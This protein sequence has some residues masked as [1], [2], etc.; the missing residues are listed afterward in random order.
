MS[1]STAIPEPPACHALAASS[2]LR[3][4]GVGSAPALVLGGAILLWG[5]NW[6]VMKLGLGHVSPLWF[7]ALRFATGAACLF[8]WQ[9]ARGAVW[10]PRG[11]DLP[12]IASIGL[13]Q[14]MLF[15]ALGAVAMTHLPAGRS[16]ILSY[17]TPIWVVPMAVLVFGER[18][19]RLQWAGIG[20]AALG[21]A[22]LFNPHAIDW[23]DGTVLGAHGMLLAASAAWA[24]CILHLRHGRSAASAA[25]LAPWQM[26]LAAAVLLPLAR[27]T[28]GPFTGDGTVTFWACLIFVGPLAT[29]FGFCAVNAA[30]RQ[31]PASRMSTLMLAVPVTGLAIATVT[32]HEMPEPDLVLGALAIILGIAAS[33]VPARLTHPHRRKARN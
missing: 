5:A 4:A 29:A 14:M 27:A 12:F 19:G 11:A 17:T 21:V 15:T 28:E 7:S 25:Q 9:A 18:L 33:A 1:A 31:V 22:I 3:R 20:L 26:L 2:A 24:V 8:A 30:S 23:R 6:P 13:L 10:R 16:A 32:L